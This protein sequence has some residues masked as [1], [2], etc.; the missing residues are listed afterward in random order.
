MNPDEPASSIT[1]ILVALDADPL[2]SGILEVAARFAV[3]LQGQLSGLFV[4]DVNL[5]RLT[6]L[7]FAQRSGLWSRGRPVTFQSLQRD[8]E[9]TAETMRAALAQLATEEQLPWSFEVVQ[10]SLLRVLLQTSQQAD[11]LLIVR[12]GMAV[13]ATVQPIPPVRPPGRSTLVLFEDAATSARIL[14]A[15][16]QLHADQPER[17]IV[18]LAAADRERLP[19]LRKQVAEICGENSDRVSVLP[20]AIAAPEQLCATVHRLVPGLVLMS[21]ESLLI[22]HVNL[23]TFASRLNCPLGLFR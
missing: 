16:L 10:G 2:G 21:R 13:Y 18:L 19:A 1:R 20:D 6:G 23:V 12:Q 9:A 15:A 17:I 4:Q 3:Q 7:P 8:M 22:G 5:L 14:R 11:V